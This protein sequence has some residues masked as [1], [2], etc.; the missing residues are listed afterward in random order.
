MKVLFFT[1]LLLS[2]SQA[3]AG[4]YGYCGPGA[5]GGK[6]PKQDGGVDAACKAHDDCLCGICC[7]L[8]NNKPKYNECLW[9][10]AAAQ[11]ACHK[12]F[13]E[14]IDASTP[15]DWLAGIVKGLAVDRANSYV[16]RYCPQGR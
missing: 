3:Q 6:P 13:K 14:K 4:Y 10:Q 15:K 11:C 12:K 8:F 9:A 2:F 5:N 1:I 16:Q 7:R